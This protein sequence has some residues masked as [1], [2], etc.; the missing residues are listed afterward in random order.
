MEIKP[1]PAAADHDIHP[2]LRDRWS[3]R[4]FSEEA[5]DEETIRT[6]LEAARWA[7][8]C[9]NE[10]P[11]RYLVAPR[12]NDE[13]FAAMLACLGEKNQIW[14][15]KAGVLMIA[16]ARTT[17]AHNDKPNRHAWH[18]VGL[19]NAQLTAQATAMGL[20]VHQMAG[21][22]SEAARE[23]YGIPE[24]F[25]PVAAIAIGKLAPADALPDPLK[26][27]ELAPRSRK[28]MSEI[29]FAGSW[30]EAY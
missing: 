28:A 20:G 27:R 10:Q 5:L 29:A 25:E 24:G 8:S 22:S 6:L 21:F 9:F 17:F 16:C 26:E 1:K 18:D 23:T 13:A 15:K 2:L 11:W 12:S 3:P 14:A 4:S 19:A 30:S 7:A